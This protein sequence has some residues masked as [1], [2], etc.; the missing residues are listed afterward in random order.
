MYVFLVN[1]AARSGR[2]RKCWEAV[3]TALE[4]K[5][6]SYQVFF[7][8]GAGD[9]TWLAK[10]L[11]G[12]ERDEEEVHLVVVGGD[13]TVNEVLQGIED[14]EHTRFSYI[15]AGSSNDLA[16][17]CGISGD[18]LEALE[19]LLLEAEEHRMDVG[20][21]HYHSAYLPAAKRASFQEVSRPDRRFLVSCGIGFDAGVCQKAMASPIKDVF[22]R[23][24]LGKLTYLSIALKL[25]FSSG[26]AQASLSIEDKEGKP[27]KVLSFYRLM[28]IACMS[29]PYEGGG[30]CFCPGADASDGKLDLCTVSDVPI[31]KVLL[32]LPTAFRGQH[33]R[34]KGVERYD[35]SRLRIH[36]S[37]PLWVHTDGEVTALSDDISICCQRGHLRFYY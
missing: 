5:G 31:W 20:V 13:G 18:P 33:Y 10:K 22:N 12:S 15:P 8:E 21:L 16:R 27:L 11:T 23:I 7:S 3:R 1:P 29:H 19:H 28:F 17:A 32:V 24:G 26:R 30:F 2:G 4:E 9:M 37:A 36:T 14:F 35:A 25:L 6:I 34:Y